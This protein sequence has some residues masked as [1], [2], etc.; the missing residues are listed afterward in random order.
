MSINLT[1]WDS[2]FFSYMK[3]A[4]KHSASAQAKVTVISKTVVKVML[5]SLLTNYSQNNWMLPWFDWRGGHEHSNCLENA[6]SGFGRSLLLAFLPP[7]S[8]QT[9]PGSGT[10]GTF[11]QN[12]K[13]SSI[14]HS[15]CLWLPACGATAGP[16]VL[17][18]LWVSDPRKHS[19]LAKVTAFHT[20]P[21]WDRSRGSSQTIRCSHC[22]HFSLTLPKCFLRMR[23]G[24]C[25]I[26]KSLP[27]YSISEQAL[28][29]IYQSS[30]IW[31]QETFTMDLGG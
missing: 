8:H 24:S 5:S 12:S 7:F 10:K 4:Q 30:E 20:V 14:F 16:P 1:T 22:L 18:V 31:W 27:G 6:L 17:D 13:S 25:R 21:F 2:S 23:L 28:T 29:E 3:Q 15:L 26:C 19:L 9:N 11:T